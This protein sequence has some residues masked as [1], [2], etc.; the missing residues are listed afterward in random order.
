MSEQSV[1]TEIA[2]RVWRL[3]LPLFDVNVTLVAGE[4]GLVLVD[5]YCSPAHLRPVLETCRRLSPL[6]L[7]AAVNTH[8]HFDHTFGNAALAEGGVRL[9]CHEEAARELPGHAERIQQRAAAERAEPGYAEIADAPVRV[10]DEVFSSVRVLDLGGRRI[11]LLHPGRGHTGGDLVALVPDAD[12]VL[13]G[14]LVEQAGDGV[15]GLG[16]DCWLL[17]WPATLDVVLGLVGPGTSVLP[18]HGDPVGRDFVEQQRNDIAIVA[19]QVR[20]LAGRGVSVEDALVRGE[21]PWPAERVADGIRAAY[22]QLPREG[23]GLPLA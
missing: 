12:V 23:R 2:D 9:L 14:D 10:P 8:A 13:A 21:W 1:V 22:R 20:T 3:R 4:D 16:G 18:G 11:E 6:P 19:E 7:L 17:E 5:T 15:P